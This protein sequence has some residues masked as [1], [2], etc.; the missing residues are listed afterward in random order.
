[1]I[2]FK[3]EDSLA[4]VLTSSKYKEDSA[5]IT[6]ASQE[7]LKSII[8]R[9]IYK[10]NSSLKPLLICGNMVKLEYST[11]NSGLNFIKSLE[12]Q[13]DNST[14][15]LTYSSSMILLYL[16]ELTLCLY[17]YGDCF[18]FLEVHQLLASLKKDADCLSIC[19]LLIGTLYKNLGIQLKLDHCVRCENTKDIIAISFEDGGFICKKCYRKQDVLPQEKNDLYVLK[20]AFSELNEKILH[21]TVPKENGVRILCLLHEHL[22]SYFDLKPSRT[23]PMLLTA[24]S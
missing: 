7:G 5:I 17:Q 22:Y 19:L 13:S 16:Q 6:I 20:F 8:A 10:K 21:T 24:L 4:L 15:M 23:F 18:P 9:G 2:S 11:T 12:V 3:T 1:M 14:L